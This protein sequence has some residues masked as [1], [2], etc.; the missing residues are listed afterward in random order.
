MGLMLI[1]YVP[2]YSFTSGRNQHH[3]SA[4][5]FLHYFF[6]QA[7]ITT[8]ALSTVTALT[9]CFFQLHCAQTA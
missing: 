3:F 2:P 9:S 6:T 7:L 5:F 8:T 4:S 1:L